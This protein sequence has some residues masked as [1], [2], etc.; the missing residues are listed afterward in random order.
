[1][2]NSKKSKLFKSRFACIFPMWLQN[3]T[4]SRT[5]ASRIALEINILTFWFQV[6]RNFHLLMC[7]L[8]LYDLVSL[9]LDIGCF[10]VGKL[11]AHYQ[12]NILIF[13]I[14]YLIPLTQVSTYKHCYEWTLVSYLVLLLG[15]QFWFGIFFK[16]TIP[17]DQSELKSLGFQ[18]NTVPL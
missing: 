15:L 9:I 8:A 3:Q 4:S 10:S 12:D 13:A 2:I 16:T 18:V 6:M 14:P 7:S 1:M 17:R 11:S 5:R